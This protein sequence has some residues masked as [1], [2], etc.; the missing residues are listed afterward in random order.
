MNIINLSSNFPNFSDLQKIEKSSILVNAQKVNAIFSD[1][2]ENIQNK[3]M[4]INLLRIIYKSWPVYFFKIFG[5]L[6][7]KFIQNLLIDNRYLYIQHL[8]ILFLKEIYSDETEEIIPES[9]TYSIYPILFEFYKNKEGG[10]LQEEAKKWI[11]IFSLKNYSNAK[12]VS[13]IKSM[14]GTDQNTAAFVYECVRSAIIENKNTFDI[15]FS[16]D[17]IMNCLEINEEKNKDED[18]YLKMKQL[19][20]LIKKNL[21]DK[22]EKEIKERLSEGNKKIYMELIS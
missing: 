6:K 8:S 12:Y 11:Q 18:Y 17:D 2:D 22:D 16:L 10:V 7:A 5:A 19:F 20:I 9:I 15:N 21:E 3:I 1:P 14:K 4:G 13:L